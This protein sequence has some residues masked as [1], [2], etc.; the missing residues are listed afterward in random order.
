MMYFSSVKQ[1]DFIKTLNVHQTTF[2]KHLNSGTY[3]LNKYVFSREIVGEAIAVEMSIDE[4][5]A[6]LEQDR[7]HFNRIK[8]IGSS[9]KGEKTKECGI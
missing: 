8:A 9:A 2:T 4:I 5:K 7:V 3:Y 6:M 1:I